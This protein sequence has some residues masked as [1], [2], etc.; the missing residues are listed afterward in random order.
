MIEDKKSELKLMVRL[1]CRSRV[2]L[3]CAFITN[4]FLTAKLAALPEAITVPWHSNE[5]LLC[6]KHG[7]ST[8][9]GLDQCQHEKGARS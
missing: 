3:S 9:A 2:M 4:A 5:R 1:S 6:L 8:V 7:F